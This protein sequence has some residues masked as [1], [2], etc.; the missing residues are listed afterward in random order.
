MRFAAFIFAIGFGPAFA[1]EAGPLP[2]AA[3]IVIL[4]EVHDNPD[5][6]RNQAAWIAQIGPTAVVFEMLTPDQ[7]AI[8]RVAGAVDPEQIGWAESG[9]PDFA[10]YAP[11]FDAAEGVPISGGQV[12][13]DQVRQ[14]FDIGAEAAFEQ[15]AGE[16]GT[17]WALGLGEPLPPEEQA[18]RE[19]EQNA[20]HCDAL[21]SEMLPGFVEA[22][23]LR[24]AALAAATLDALE[25]NGPPVVLIT[26]NGHARR[27][28]GVPAY[29]AQAAPGR[30]VLS[31]G[32]YQD[33]IPDGEIP[34]DHAVAAPAA[35]RPDPCA[36][37]R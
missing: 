30:S 33:T 22:Q 5:H 20:A 31:V 26:G 21:P 7:A 2:L 9:W 12:P 37:F 6:H 17:G 11:V 15:I 35:Q 25:A 28:W 16:Y 18:A 32:Q 4:G 29:I 10:V 3:D 34:F 1:E 27:D 24:D 13:R 19:A 36:V 14:A 23:R 8:I